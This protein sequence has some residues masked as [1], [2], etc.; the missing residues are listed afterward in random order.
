MTAPTPPR[1]GRRAG[2]AQVD[3]AAADRRYYDFRTQL[4]VV[5]TGD[6]LERLEATG[7]A[8]LAEKHVELPAGI[9]TAVRGNIA[10][11]RI[12]RLT[13]EAG[14]AFRLTRAEHGDQ[15]TWVTEIL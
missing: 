11:A 5:D 12:D 7:R 2:P 10:E 1:T 6:W 13:S 8:W 4:R 15:G 3:L 9:P 14:D